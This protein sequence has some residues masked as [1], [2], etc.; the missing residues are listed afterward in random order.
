MIKSFEKFLRDKNPDCCLDCWGNGS[1]QGTLPITKKY[2]DVKCPTCAGTGIDKE[3][4]SKG[5]AEG[6]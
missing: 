6:G 2:I 5:W 1:L 3:H 4:K